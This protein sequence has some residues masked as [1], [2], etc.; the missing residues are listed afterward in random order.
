MKE[1]LDMKEVWY[2]RLVRQ[3]L[4]NWHDEMGATFELTI[5]CLQQFSQQVLSF[6]SRRI[7]TQ[8]PAFNS[9]LTQGWARAGAS[10]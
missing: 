9:E 4:L 7:I 8:E 1:D 3:K 2:L 5:V 10:I 6:Q